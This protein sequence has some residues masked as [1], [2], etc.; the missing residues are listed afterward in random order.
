[1]EHDI[2]LH[3]FI[4][5][6]SMGIAAQWFA[7]R[8]KIPSIVLLSAAGITAGPVFQW[9]NPAQD[10]GEFML[11]LI[12][13]AVAII[14]FEGGL[15][16]HLHELKQAGKAVRQLILF[17][18]P[19]AWLFGFLASYYV[20]GLSFPVAL[21]LAAILVVTGPTVIMPL[22]RQTKISPRLASLFK[23]EGIVNDPLGALL[24]VFVF[25][26][27]LASEHSDPTQQILLSIG[28]AM[29]VSAALG[30]G[31]GVFLK[32]AFE[33]GFIPEFL[34]VPLILSMVF[35]IYGTANSVQEEAGL[36][37]VT[38]FGIMVGNIGLAIIHEL[39]RFKENITTLLVSTVFIILTAGLN[40]AQLME[41]EWRSAAFLACLLF[42]ARPAA[43]WLSTIGAG[44]NWNER[45]LLSWIAPRGVVAASVAGLLAPKMIEHGYPDAALL[46]PLV[47]AVVF[48]TV[49]LHGFSFSWAARALGLS[50]KN[51][52]GVMIVGASPWSIELASAIKQAGLPVLLVDASWHNLKKAR[53]QAI[54]VYYGEVLS[55]TSEQNLDLSEMG[56]LLT[57][58]VNDA[59]NALV[60][61]AFVHHFGRER[62]YQLASHGTGEESRKE[63]KSSSRGLT[64]FND[65][66]RYE[67][68][69]SLYY[70][71]WRF[72]KTRLTEEFDYDDFLT[73]VND[74]AKP[75]L[76]IQESGKLAFAS[77]A[78][79][80]KPKPG[81]TLL[82]FSNPE[83]P[84]ESA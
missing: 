33:K 54:P 81:D 72:Q 15:N 11:V 47:F 32:Y 78:Q 60:S 77:S 27:F 37:A 55:Q 38:V 19:L 63:V 13:L 39:R 59:Y 79:E 61:G 41:M 30:L 46:V 70:Q 8:F 24:A 52:E 10:F 31:S 4:L 40:P 2:L 5:V 3:K 48:S 35:L 73:S 51:Q 83:K 22:I 66:L 23:W 18:L 82:S 49:V 16:L 42:L 56:Y 44:L 1:M 69:L 36:L 62:V 50:A 71:G 25:Q 74:K 43:V 9:I 12:K 29:T 14:L 26:F 34:K 65:E 64:A 45:L 80:M 21:L 75:L 53:L 84:N 7:W 76:L 28:L 6:I 20:E 68:F 67:T 57:A 17:G 58:T